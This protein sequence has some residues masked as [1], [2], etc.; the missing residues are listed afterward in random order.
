VDA[1]GVKPPKE[2]DLE[3]FFAKSL[4]DEDEEW[5]QHKKVIDTK[6]KKGQIGRCIPKGGSFNYVHIDFNGDGGF[7]HVIEDKRKFKRITPL[8]VLG[9]VIGNEFTNLTA[10]MRKEKAVKN[11]IEI[12]KEFR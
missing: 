12:R 7:A 4:E 9:S 10:P 8:E 3:V 2:I 6:R 11:T 1:V 5:S